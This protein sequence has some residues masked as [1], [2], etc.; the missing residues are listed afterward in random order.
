VRFAHAGLLHRSYTTCTHQVHPASQCA[1]SCAVGL[2]F[3]RCAYS[4]VRSLRELTRS[5]ATRTHT[6]VRCANSHVRSLRELTRSSTA[7]THTFVR[8]AYSLLSQSRCAWQSK[9]GIHCALRGGYISVLAL[10]STAPVT[11]N[12][13]PRCRGPARAKRCAHVTKLGSNV[14]VIHS[15]TTCANKLWGFTILAQLT[16]A[17]IFQ[18]GRAVLPRNKS[19]ATE[20]GGVNPPRGATCLRQ[21]AFC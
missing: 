11:V 8:C 1:H 19:A 18:S 6:F 21:V 10:C 14:T 9:S 2:T 4:H 5:F 15:R 13:T 17:L 16:Q 7:C 20:L 3:V 12:K